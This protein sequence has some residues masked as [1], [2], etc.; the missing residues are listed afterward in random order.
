MHLSAQEP[1]VHI[2][3]Q[4]FQQ[5]QR[6]ASGTLFEGPDRYAVW[7]RQDAPPYY[8]A[9]PAPAACCRPQHPH[10]NATQ[11][12]KVRM[13]LEIVGLFLLILDP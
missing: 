5:H 4:H 2:Q 13:Y 3:E 11:P 6:T 7:K 12:L 1:H 8:E 10:H 9:P